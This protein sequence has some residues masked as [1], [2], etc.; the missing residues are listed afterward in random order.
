MLSKIA[1]SIELH[2]LHIID[3]QGRD[4][5]A[6]QIQGLLRDD[7]FQE[8][9]RSL[10]LVQ[11]AD[12]DPTATWTRCTELLRVAGLPAPDIGAG[13]ASGGSLK[14]A[15]F[16]VPSRERRGATEELC[17]DSVAS[18]GRLR[19]AGNYLA[20]VASDGFPE[21]RHARK[22]LV[23]AFLAA[24]PEIARSLRVGLKRGDF[25]I[26]SSVFDEAR[27]FLQSLTSLS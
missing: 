12:N 5:W 13:A 11:D 18:D 8:N 24:M 10:G 6:P 14:T 20:A 15:V 21:P 9:V 16:V 4:G 23:Q 22:A 7:L 1:E 19:L 2:S 17:L 26:T 3:M 25:P 27:G